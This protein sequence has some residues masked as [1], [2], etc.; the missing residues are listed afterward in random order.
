MKQR[1][2]R[3]WDGF[4]YLSESDAGESVQ[5]SVP[6]ITTV[7]HFIDRAEVC[8]Y[9]VYFLFIYEEQLLSKISL[10]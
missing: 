4:G 7:P 6:S 2:G 8:S 5:K 1:F 3:L 10:L 9:F